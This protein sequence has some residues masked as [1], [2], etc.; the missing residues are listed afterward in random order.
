MRCTVNPA[1]GREKE[2]GI[3][4]LKP[5][6]SKKKILVIGSGPAGLEAAR[7]ASQR[8]HKVRIYER[9]RE[10]GGQ[11]LLAAKLPGRSDIKGIVN[12][13]LAELKKSG[14]EI[15]YGVEIMSDPD[16]IGSVMEEERPDAVV[17]ATGSHSL[18]TSLQMVT[19]R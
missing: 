18:K 1:V 19:Y 8:G 3:G 13:Q 17:V 11:A 4:T 10:A 9:S 16:V 5:A 14:V 6:E 7:V 15:K 2:R 12:W